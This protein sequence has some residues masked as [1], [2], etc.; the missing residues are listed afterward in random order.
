MQEAFIKAF[1]KRA[2]SG[3]SMSLV[4]PLNPVPASRPR[5]SKWGTYYLKTYTRWMKQAK[6]HLPDGVD[7]PALGAGPVAVLTEFIVN[8]PKT[9]KRQWPLGDVDNYEKAAWD[10]ITKCRAVW[11]D[12]DQI[13]MCLSIK[14]YAETNEEPHTRVVVI[15]L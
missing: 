10:A 1:M 8:R 6:L 12:D 7:E 4:V 3:K 11:Q 15:A 9:T 13:L 2:A 5:V 14:R